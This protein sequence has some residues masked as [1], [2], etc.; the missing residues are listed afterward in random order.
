MAK[1]K[2]YCKMG[3]DLEVPFA[4]KLLQHSKEGLTKFEVEDIYRVGL[5]GKRGS[6]HHNVV[7]VA[8]ND[9]EKKTS[10]NRVQG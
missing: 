2:E 8:I 4:Q 3:H 9:G 10:Q 7:A 5:V 6:M 1:G